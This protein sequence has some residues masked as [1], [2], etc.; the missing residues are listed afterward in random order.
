MLYI[1]YDFSN[2]K[3]RAQF[4]RFLQKYGRRIQYSLFLIHNSERV[5]QNIITEVELKYKDRFTGADSILIVPVT[6][7][8]EGKII[9][10]GYAKNDEND[11]LIFS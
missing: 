7:A 2:N 5:L 9:R 6:P 10:Y 4:S 3:V 8:D 1:S 11:V